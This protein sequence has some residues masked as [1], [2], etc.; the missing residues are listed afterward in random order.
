MT[1]PR[2]ALA[3]VVRELVNLG[4]R[5]WR[6]PGLRCRSVVRIP[7]RR[8]LSLAATVYSSEPT[9]L[10][11][12]MGAPCTF[13]GLEVSLLPAELAPIA[14]WVAR[15]CVARANG[16]DLLTGPAVP[17]EVPWLAP[18]NV[19]TLGAAEVHDAWARAQRCAA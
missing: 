4:A 9:I 14:P 3:V 16:L 10:R 1:R 6:L 11:F 17:L 5:P 18:S 7:G 8:G 19:W 15:L 2:E 13:G 12:T